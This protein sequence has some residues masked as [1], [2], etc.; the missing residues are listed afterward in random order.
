MVK[1]RGQTS[2]KNTVKQTAENEMAK[3]I[4]RAKDTAGIMSLVPSRRSKIQRLRNGLE[5]E[6]AFL[7]QLIRSGRSRTSWIAPVTSPHLTHHIQ[8]RLNNPTASNVPAPWLFGC[9]DPK[10]LCASEHLSEGHAFDLHPGQPFSLVIFHF[11]S[12]CLWFSLSKCLFFAV[13]LS[14]TRRRSPIW[15]RADMWD[16]DFMF[17]SIRLAGHNPRVLK[18]VTRGNVGI[19]WVEMRPNLK[20]DFDFDGALQHVTGDK[21]DY[22]WGKFIS[23][24]FFSFHSNF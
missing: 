11:H 14:I 16:T 2:N 21:D 6:I 17:S 20:Q 5:C 24:V 9:R 10:L 4:S 15:Q 7:H 8:L 12:G 23:M 22:W 19:N 13:A 3:K 1:V 18:R